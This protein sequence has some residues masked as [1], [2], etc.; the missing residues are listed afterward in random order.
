MA[1]DVESVT[2]CVPLHCNV[3]LYTTRYLRQAT[4]RLESNN[5]QLRDKC[6]RQSA[7]I[8]KLKA[9]EEELQVGLFFYELICMLSAL[10][11]IIAKC[12][13]DHVHQ[14]A[15]MKQG[16][17]VAH[18]IDRRVASELECDPRAIRHRHAHCIS[19]VFLFTSGTSDARRTKT[20]NELE[21]RVPIWRSATRWLRGR[22]GTRARQKR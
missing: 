1:Q 9:H 10:V 13:C 14:A 20:W 19:H 15:V 4:A 17:D 12:D 6:E 11:H 7:R 2:S 21:S 16:A 8:Q 22:R 5:T 18:A 3:T